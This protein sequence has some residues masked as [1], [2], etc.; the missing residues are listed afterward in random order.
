MDRRSAAAFLLGLGLLAASS[1]G[2]V[3]NPRCWCRFVLS[4]LNC[5][6]S[7]T[8]TLDLATGAGLLMAAAVG[9][10]EVSL[11]VIQ[12]PIFWVFEARLLRNR[13]C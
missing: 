7:V 6:K 12:P 13:W 2:T 8:K 1:V 9:H 5:L 10:A 3:G 4:S 11:G